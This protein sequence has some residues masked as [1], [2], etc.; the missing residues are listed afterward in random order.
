MPTRIYQSTESLLQEMTF[1]HS[2]AFAKM[3]GFI[4]QA[5]ECAVT[6][7]EVHRNRYDYHAHSIHGGRPALIDRR[8]KPLQHTDADKADILRKLKSSYVA[9]RGR[10][11][12]DGETPM[13]VEKVRKIMHEIFREILPRHGY[14]TRDGQIE[15]AEKLLDTITTR[16]TLLAEA[17]VG[18]GKTLSYIIPAILVK[19][20]RCNEFHGAS[21]FP[22]M[23]Y[24]E[25]KR[26]PVVVSTASIALQRAIEREVIPEISR[27]LQEAGVIRKPL[28]AVL[29]KGK[30]HYVCERNL[31]AHIPYEKKPKI[32][33]ALREI[34]CDGRKLDLADIGELTPHVKKKICVPSKCKRNCPNANEC[35]F[36]TYREAMR[37][38][39][40]DIIICN[41]NLLI[42]DAKLRAETGKSVL[43]PY[44]AVIFDEAHEVLQASR[45]IYGAT[46]GGETIPKIARSIFDLNFEPRNSEGTDDWRDTRNIAH[47]LAE[48]LFGQ[49]KRVFAKTNAGADCDRLLTR[50]RNIAGELHY[51]LTKTYLPK[52]KLA[53]ER[54]FAL[55]G[56]LERLIK[57][58]TPMTSSVANIRWFESDK[59]GNTALCSL[60]T[61]LSEIL[62]NDLW[63]RGV[64]SM[65]TSGTLSVNGDFG[66]LK[67]SL[68]LSR[69]KHINET[70]HASPYDY[71]KNCLLY[72][73]ENMP[74]PKQSS[75][76][77]IAALTNEIE[78]L[79]RVAHGHTAV[80]FT[81]YYVMDI[82]HSELEK[83]G[84]PFPLF[85]LERS[86]STAIEQFK[87]SKNGVL[88][89]SGSLWQGIDIPG[90]L[91]S[92]LIIAKLPFQQPNAIN[93]YERSRYP[94]FNS[95]LNAVIIP[96]MLIKLKQGFG[97]L[98]RSMTDT[99]VVAILDSRVNNRGKFRI[100]MLDALPLCSVTSILAQIDT[101]LR[102]VKPREYYL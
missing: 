14:I 38:N 57:L 66:V 61:N 90:D 12:I 65:L 70:T 51:V 3:D 64:P 55:L 71:E 25:W 11:E 34:A 48:K 67:Q 89:A 84:I 75:K 62:H 32:A 41:H 42:A 77:Y 98:L 13:R 63:K 100:S 19:R 46:F 88:L 6:E 22:Q 80:L 68:G 4:F 7:I 49:N 78:K 60:P 56:E 8:R 36:K 16:G 30:S 9:G 27:I 29:A 81:S 86:T 76:K 92:M 73:P 31:R 58:V 10:I 72:I 43:P 15:L 39:E 20:S 53:E 18:S 2:E 101:F 69:M 102:S 94:D 37:K 93:E 45:S 35:R 24:V 17:A 50:I 99:G 91:L 40:A 85:K 82:V 44:Q 52:C 5:F 59:Q 26:M 97:R 23:S 33:A 95:Y 87:E 83:R 1:D 54:R 21:A 28:V 74:F 47:R 96:E 79:I